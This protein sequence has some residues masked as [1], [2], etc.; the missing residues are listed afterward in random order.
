MSTN[1]ARNVSNHILSKNSQSRKGGRWLF[2]NSGD[3]EWHYTTNLIL[4]N[5]KLGRWIN[6]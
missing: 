4:Y 5:L 2:H 3:N 6:G 1:D